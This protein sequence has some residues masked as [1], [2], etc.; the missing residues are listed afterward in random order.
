M[1]LSGMDHT[2]HLDPPPLSPIIL[3]SL[4]LAVRSLGFGRAAA[5][6]AFTASAA[7]EIRK[8]YKIN[9]HFKRGMTSRH[10]YSRNVPAALDLTPE[11][12]SF[13]SLSDPPPAE[14]RL[15]GN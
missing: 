9:A 1:C 11:D 2:F 14:W 4:C 7:A 3:P 5:T 6:T 8:L 10:S 13:L 12:W 15:D